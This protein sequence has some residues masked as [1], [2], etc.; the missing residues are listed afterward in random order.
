MI[1]EFIYSFVCADFDSRWATEGQLENSDQFVGS[2]SDCMRL[3]PGTG[4]LIQPCG[5]DTVPQYIKKERY[6]YMIAF[7][8]TLD[9]YYMGAISQIE[10][11]TVYKSH[12]LQLNCVLWRVHDNSATVLL[13]W[14]LVPA[15]R[16]WLRAGGR[17]TLLSLSSRC[18][19]GPGARYLTPHCWSGA[20]QGSTTSSRCR[21]M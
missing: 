17:H 20:A 19:K 12:P 1:S 14:I 11:R 7:D 9:N 16:R 2:D 10:Q 3:T 13:F 21:H 4:P 18:G 5:V 15:G 8:C 6:R